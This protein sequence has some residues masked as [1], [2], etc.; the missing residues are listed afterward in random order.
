M[1]HLK[2]IKSLKWMI[3]DLFQKGYLKREIAFNPSALRSR[4]KQYR[5]YISELG[6]KLL[7]LSLS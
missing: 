2:D 3:R 6:K 1:N 5:Y 7:D 4:K